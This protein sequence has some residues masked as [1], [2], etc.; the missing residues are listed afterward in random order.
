MRAIPRLDFGRARVIASFGADFLGTWISPVEFAHGWRAGRKLDAAAPNDPGNA[1]KHW[2]IEARTSMTGLRADRR[3]R[4]GPWETGEALAELCDALAAKAGTASKLAASAPRAWVVELA[5]ELWAA[6]GESLVVSDDGDAGVQALVN[7]ANERL[8]NYGKTLDLREPSRARLGDDS[9]VRAL[10]DEMNA[11]GI[12][13][14]VVAGCNPAYDLV[15]AKFGEAAAKV[16]FIVAVAPMPDETTALAHAVAPRLHALESWDD[17]EPVAGTLSLTQPAIRALRDGR[18]L[19][20]CLARWCGDTRPDDE[21]L[22]DHWRRQVLPTP[23][24]DTA[25]DGALERGFLRRPPGTRPAPRYRAEAVTAP[26]ARPAPASGSFAAV[27]YAKV[28]LLDGSQAHNAWLQELPDP[29]SKTTWDNYACLSPAAAASLGVATG[30]VVR[31]TSDGVPP[32]ELPAHVQPGQHDGVVAI[33][34]GYGRVGTDRFALAGPQWLESKPTVEAGG[35]VGRSAAAFAAVGGATARHV[36]VERT[37]SRHPLACT[38]DHHSLHVPEHLAPRDGKVRDAA[39]TV[40]LATWAE[41]PAHATERH[42]PSAG[43]DLWAQDHVVAGHRWGMVIDLAA[44]D[45]CSACVVACQAENNIPVVGRDEVLRHREMQWL[46]IDRYYDGDGDGDDVSAAQQPMACQHCAN[47]PCETVCPVLA[48]T[49]SSE[50]LNQQT[51]NRCVGTR[52]CANNCPYKVR[53]FNW[54]DYPREDL[55]QNMAL[56]PDVTVRT[57]GVMEKCSL[58]VQRIQGAKADAKRRGA[59]Y[60]D[61]DAVTACQQSCPAGAISFGDLNDPASAVSRR[62]ADGRGYQVLAELNVK[63]AVTYLADVRNRPAVAEEKH[64]GG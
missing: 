19:R 6:R 48:T 12:A 25:F 60:A 30:D 2:Q 33:A 47:A 8:G 9:A 35:T 24:F 14:L 15:A 31:V 13:A 1:A 49:H 46:R 43:A 63:P 53:R 17:A 3:V 57:R 44:C 11:G 38:Q 58:C 42:A 4:L 36:R 26:A 45:G 7:A 39:R 54:F 41:D 34:I 16:P 52:Y 50:G 5:A 40:A 20:A 55:L 64:H 10:V 59:A 23:D 28:G 22:R 56:N 37:G 51:Y 18:T 62:A 27:L 29:V 21:L 61:G 32:L